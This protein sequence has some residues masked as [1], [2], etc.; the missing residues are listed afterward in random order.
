MTVIANDFVPIVPY[1]TNVVSLGVG[2]RA[3]VIVKATGKPTD[4]VW[5]RSNMSTQCSITQQPYALAP[6]Y[7][8]QANTS[9]TPRTVAHP[10]TE[11]GC[12]NVRASK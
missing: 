1:E 12:I 4:A 3:D 11:T 8:S 10:Y 9:G 5:M 2:Q 7:Y 6:I